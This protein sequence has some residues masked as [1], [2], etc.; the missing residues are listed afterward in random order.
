MHMQVSQHGLMAP[1]YFCCCWHVE[2]CDHK[3]E[4]V[5]CRMDDPVKFGCVAAY[6]VVACFYV[7]VEMDATL[8]A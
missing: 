4:P 5:R 2:L 8:M 7:V 3:D 6:T 1:A